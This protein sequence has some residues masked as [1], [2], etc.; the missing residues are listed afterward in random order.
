VDAEPQAATP[1]GAARLRRFNL[2]GVVTCC[3]AYAARVRGL[4]SS[5]RSQWTGCLQLFAAHSRR[6]SQRAGAM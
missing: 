1:V 4:T 5:V 2:D 6:Y 3:R